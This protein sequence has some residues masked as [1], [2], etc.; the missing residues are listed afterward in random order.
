ME[1]FTDNSTGAKKEKSSGCGS[2]RAN[3]KSE[4]KGDEKEIET[5]DDE[6]VNVDAS[7]RDNSQQK[8]QDW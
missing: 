1:T 6:I 5:T 3:A 8:H 2:G 7:R 4:I